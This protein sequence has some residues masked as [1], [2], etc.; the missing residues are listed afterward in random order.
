MRAHKRHTNTLTHVCYVRAH[1]HIL[2]LSNLLFLYYIIYMQSE[3]KM[4]ETEREI[5]IMRINDEKKTWAKRKEGIEPKNDMCHNATRN[6]LL[7]L[8]LN[9]HNDI[10]SKKWE[11]ISDT[12]TYTHTHIHSHSQSV[13]LVCWFEAATLSLK[14]AHV[15]L[16]QFQ[17]TISWQ[18]EW[19]GK[20]I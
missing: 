16:F 19:K 17:S 5:W 1:T 4:N 20:G 15:S 11:P 8:S 9:S 6:W 7:G 13:Y 18:P 2:S 10:H 14:I 12:F 3:W